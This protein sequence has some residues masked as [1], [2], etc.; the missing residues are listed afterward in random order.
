MIKVFTTQND[1]ALLH[2][3]RKALEG[4]GFKCLV[5]NE[6]RAGIAAGEIPP[7]IL[8]PELYILDENRSREAV[9]LVAE[10]TR[11]QLYDATP[12]TCVECGEESEGN[13]HACWNCGAQRGSGSDNSFTQSRNGTVD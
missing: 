5:R 9:E 11:F 2:L 1:V 8:W 7:L 12:W 10:M 3:I 4:R 13:F 6:H